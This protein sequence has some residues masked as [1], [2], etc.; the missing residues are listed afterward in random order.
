MTIPA[1]TETVKDAVST[2]S[3]L[4]HIR[5]NKVEYLLGYNLLIERAEFSYTLNPT[6]VD[7]VRITAT[8]AGETWPVHNAHVKAHAMW[9]EMNRLVLEDNP[10]IVGK[11][12]DFKLY[13]DADM[14]TGVTNIP[15][16]GTGTPVTLG[17]WEYS[18]FVLPEHDVDPVTGAPLP[19]DETFAHLEWVE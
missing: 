1:A 6:L 16:G 10:S 17:E 11:W 13:L 19:A 4:N 2:A 3:V 15:Y 7:V 14:A 12:H 18:K 8:T 5:T 9:N